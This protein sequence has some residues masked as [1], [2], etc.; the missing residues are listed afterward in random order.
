MPTSKLINYT[1]R[2]FMSENELE[3][4]AKK[5]DEI[6][7][8]KV[9]EEFKKAG[10]LRRVLTRIWNK[11]GSEKGKGDWVDTSKKSENQ[12][13]ELVSLRLDSRKA[14]TS[15][16][17]RTIYSFETAINQTI[18]WYQSYYNNDTSM[19]ELSV[20]Q[21][22]RYSKTADQTNITWAGN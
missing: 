4:Y 19:K 11:E 9:I 10:M 18:S 17:W 7:T 6:F 8:P 5:Q 13:N 21:I 15:L 12:P 20:H 22:E 3:L 2:E 1:T 14:L 16:E